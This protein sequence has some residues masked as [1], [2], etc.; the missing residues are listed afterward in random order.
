MADAYDETNFIEGGALQETRKQEDTM[1]TIG[2]EC[3]QSAGLL[4]NDE[5]KQQHGFG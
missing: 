1:M 4:E 2:L 3:D 5:G